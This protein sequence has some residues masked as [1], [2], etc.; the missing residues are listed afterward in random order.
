M[1]V[2]RRS[3][4]RLPS[5]TSSSSLTEPR[6]GPAGAGLCVR[7]V[8]REPVRH[9]GSLHDGRQ[10]LALF[11]GLP[12]DSPVNTYAVD[13]VFQSTSTLGSEMTCHQ[14]QAI[15]FMKRAMLEAGTRRILMMDGS[16]VGRTSLHHFVPVSDFTDV[17]LT[18][19]VPAQ[20]RDA[21]AANCK[22][23]I[24]LLAPHRPAQSGDFEKAILTVARQSADQ[25]AQR[26]GQVPDFPHRE[27]RGHGSGAIGAGRNHGVGETEPVRLLDALVDARDGADF[28]GQAHLTE[29]DE[30]LGNGFLA[31]ADATASAT[32][33][34]VAGSLSFTP[35]TV[36]TGIISCSVGSRH[37]AAVRQHRRS[38]SRPAAAPG[39]AGN[40][41]FRPAATGPPPA[42]GGALPGS[43]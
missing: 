19:D 16:K 35:P 8:P 36:A 27:T 38:V 5:T 33:R 24:A 1:P 31:L 29:S 26:F 11:I 23:H 15:V 13:I 14:E 37:A 4:A 9:L 22:V 18:D 7:S 2:R 3:T 40:W 41:S 21:A 30:P 20:D 39:A 34:S 25:Q 10:G 32:A 6:P 42:A 43:P 17:I 12:T 28:P